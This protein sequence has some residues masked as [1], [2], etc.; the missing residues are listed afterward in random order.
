MVANWCRSSVR[1]RT[2]S[3][4]PTTRIMVGTVAV[5][6]LISMPR[7]PNSPTTTIDENAA[8]AIGMSETRTS[9]KMIQSR[10]VSSAIAAGK[11]SSVSCCTPFAIASLVTA[12]PAM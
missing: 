10:I 12:G 6:M 4:S 2:Q 5:A 7:K 11:N 3:G 1:K 8:T 9:P